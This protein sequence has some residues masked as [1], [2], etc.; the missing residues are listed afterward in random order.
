MFENMLVCL[1]GS[2]LAE[3]ILPYAE[4]QALKFNSR[5]TLL[6][7]VV[8]NVPEVVQAGATYKQ[9]TGAALRSREMMEKAG[10]YLDKT[11]RVLR[12]KGIRV[13]TVVLEAASVGDAILKY[14]RD[15]GTDFILM[16][17]HGRGG[18]RHVVMGS[19]AEHVMKASALP[20]LIIRPKS[21]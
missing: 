5:V 9:S 3:Q 17:T 13:E 4:V 6:Q 10:I 15:N 7:V 18:I 19:V 8:T 12:E 11:A 14:A 1:D 21:Q 16:A 20:I 2:I